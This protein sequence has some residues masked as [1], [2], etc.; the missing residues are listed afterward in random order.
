MR[1]PSIVASRLMAIA[2]TFLLVLPAARAQ[3]RLHRRVLEAFRPVVSESSKS[4]TRI[5]CDGSQKALGAVVQADGYIVT[6]ASEL[7][8]NIEVQTHD[9]PRKLSAITRAS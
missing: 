8:G 6:K 1:K 5:Y 2:I 9:I 3:D 7:S 4:T